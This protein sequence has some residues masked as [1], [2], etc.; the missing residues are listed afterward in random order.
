[1]AIRAQHNGVIGGLVPH[2][3]PHGV[4]IL[5]YA[6]GTILCLHDDLT[7]ARNMKLL[8]YMYEQMSGLKINFEISDVILIGEIIGWL[9]SMLQFLAVN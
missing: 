2:S 4:A 7:K 3:I 8:L 6:D 9:L 5:Q 1:M